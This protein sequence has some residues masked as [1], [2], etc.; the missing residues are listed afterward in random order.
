MQNTAKK[1]GA[2]LVIPKNGEEINTGKSEIWEEIRILG[3]NIY[4]CFCF[5]KIDL[6]DG[7]LWTDTYLRLDAIL[8][9]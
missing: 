8:I 1:Q 4:G 3:Q 2:S 9:T 5:K 7:Q 6:F